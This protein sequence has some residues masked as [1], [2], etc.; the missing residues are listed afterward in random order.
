MSYDT[1]PSICKQRD[2]VLLVAATSHTEIIYYVQLRQLHLSG[3]RIN[4]RRTRDDIIT[5]GNDVMTRSL[6]AD[7]GA[8]LT[9]HTGEDL[10]QPLHGSQ[11]LGLASSEA[12]L[13]L[14]ERLAH[15]VGVRDLGVVHERDV[16]HS[17]PLD[18][19]RR[20]CVTFAR[21]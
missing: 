4:G 3:S 20:V 11:G 12:V 13:K 17:P 9:H 10:G 5:P 1:P 7:S 6:G 8:A 21:L 2:S 14:V 16:P 19:K 15:R 18:D